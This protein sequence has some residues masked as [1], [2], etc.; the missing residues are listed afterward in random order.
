MTACANA[1]YRS[2]VIL[3]NDLREAERLTQW[4]IA[5]C[6]EAHIP[7]KTSFAVQLCLDEAVA[8]ILQYGEQH[9]EQGGAAS[10]I[11][12]RLE[13]S[14]SGVVLDIEDDGGAFDPT[15]AAPPAPVTTLETLPVGGLGIHF[16]RQ[17]SS[18]M[19]YS[20]E[21]GRNRLRLTFAAP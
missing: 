6:A 2:S 1:P 10:A 4:I 5:A 21:G 18:R 14:Q 7:E 3:R 12:A 17:Y 13:Y 8:N 9:R 11:A 16:I 15:R 19:E 20:R